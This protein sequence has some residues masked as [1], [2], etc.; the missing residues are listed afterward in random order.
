MN[1]GYVED[2]NMNTGL[3]APGT[4]PPTVLLNAVKSIMCLRG[5]LLDGNSKIASGEISIESLPGANPAEGF[6]IP[7]NVSNSQPVILNDPT[8]GVVETQ[9]G[10]AIDPATA[11]GFRYDTQAFFTELRTLRSLRASWV[12]QWAVLYPQIITQLSILG[13]ALPTKGVFYSSIPGGSQNPAVNIA[14]FMLVVM[15][16][17]NLVQPLKSGG[18]V[19]NYN[20]TQFAGPVSSGSPAIVNPIVQAALTNRKIGEGWPKTRGKAQTFGSNK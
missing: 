15:V 8:T 16:N 4:L 2:Y 3:G 19:Y 5:Q 18:V 14:F 1:G 6:Q 20:I 9:P 13:A 11:I 17:T 12:Q 7:H 10:L